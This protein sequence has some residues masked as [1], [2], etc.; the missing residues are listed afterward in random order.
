MARQKTK[1]EWLGEPGRD[2]I[3]NNKQKQHMSARTL[4][5]TLK[6]QKKRQGEESQWQERGNAGRLMAVENEGT[7]CSPANIFMD[8]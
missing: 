3:L 4:S 1:T 6:W 5:A 8:K 7:E 2:E